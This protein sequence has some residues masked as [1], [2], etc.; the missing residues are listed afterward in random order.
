MVSRNFLKQ[1]ALLFCHFGDVSIVYSSV[2][3]M[4]MVFVP[5]GF[6]QIFIRKGF[7]QICIRKGFIQICRNYTEEGFS[8]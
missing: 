6:I 7:I 8:K 5:K 3:Q 2:Y 4:Y 1:K